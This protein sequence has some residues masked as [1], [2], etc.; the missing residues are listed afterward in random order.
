MFHLRMYIINL[1]SGQIMPTLF[2]LQFNNLFHFC[3]ATFAAPNAQDAAY[4]FHAFLQ[5]CLHVSVCSNTHKCSKAPCKLLFQKVTNKRPE[6]VPSITANF[7]S[8]PRPPSICGFFILF[9]GKK[10]K[11]SK[12]LDFR[13][14]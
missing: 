3:A 8:K 10:K 1:N 2:D 7:Q 11:G 9:G 5:V 4:L 6:K 14:G 12:P 13:G